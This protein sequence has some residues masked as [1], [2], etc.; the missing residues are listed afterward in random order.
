MTIYQKPKYANELFFHIQYKDYPFLHSHRGYWEFMLVTDGTLYHKLNGKRRELTKG[1]LCIIRPQDAHSM[2][3]PKGGT[4]SHLNLGVTSQFLER[5]LSLL[6]ENLYKKMEA[7]PFLELRLSPQRTDKILQSAHRLLAADPSVY[8][9]RLTLL[10]LDVIREIYSYL[11]RNDKESREY[12]QPVSTLIAEMENPQ[13]MTVNIEE[14]IHKINYS[15]SHLS[16]LFREE[17]GISPSLYFKRKK[18]E[19]AKKL[20]TETDMKLT[21]IAFAIGYASY[22]HFSVS[23]KEMTGVSPVGYC[24]DKNNY[25]LSIEEV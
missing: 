11:L 3:N 25:Y 12:S 5:Y 15:Y 18:F 20:M 14:L 6:D 21:E 10:F 8:E 13:N 2:H 24:K 23:F 1:T 19:Y 22:S 17:L 7:A 16:R 4:S 9:K